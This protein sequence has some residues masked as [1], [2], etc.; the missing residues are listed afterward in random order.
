M[1]KL[2]QIQWNRICIKL[3]TFCKSNKG[4]LTTVNVITLADITSKVYLYHLPHNNQSDQAPWVA[5]NMIQADR[6]SSQWPYHKPLTLGRQGSCKSLLKQKSLHQWCNGNMLDSRSSNPHSHILAAWC[7]C[8]SPQHICSTQFPPMTCN[9]YW[10]FGSLSQKLEPR[11]FLLCL[12]SSSPSSC[13][14]LLLK[15][16][17]ENPK[18]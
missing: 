14:G 13:V 10:R 18:V 3:T 8:W 4:R 5:S 2:W 16:P 12:D 7:P 6:D 11:Q 9:W 15:A 1:N 17:T